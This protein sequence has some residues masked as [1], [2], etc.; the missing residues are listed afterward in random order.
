MKGRALPAHGVV[1]ERVGAAVD[2]TSQV[3]SEH[4]E[5]KVGLAQETVLLH[6]TRQCRHIEG[7]PSHNE[8]QSHHHNH[9]GHLNITNTYT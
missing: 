1:D 8:R 2:E 5:E 3:N 6:L 4:G 9:A 7:R